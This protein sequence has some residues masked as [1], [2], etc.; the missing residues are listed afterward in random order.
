MYQKRERLRTR[1]S[2]MKISSLATKRICGDH[3]L[4]AKPVLTNG[5]LKLDLLKRCHVSLRTA[6]LR[7]CMLP[8]DSKGKTVPDHVFAPARPAGLSRPVLNPRWHL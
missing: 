2:L 6:V 4:R 7:Y 1:R 5:A 8:L 3:G